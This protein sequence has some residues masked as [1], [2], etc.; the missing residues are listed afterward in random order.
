MS[1]AKNIA[2]AREQAGISLEELAKKATVSKTYLW[3]LEND[4][5][6]KKKP[7]ADVL[8]KIATSLGVTIADIL[9]LPSVAVDDAKIEISDSLREFR[10]WMKKR[11]KEPLNDRDVSDLATMRFRGGQPKTREDWYDLYRAL[12]NTTGN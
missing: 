8:L 10:E 12:K 2:K 4:T 5:E 3:Q 1:L 7:S 9:D 11:M 6:S